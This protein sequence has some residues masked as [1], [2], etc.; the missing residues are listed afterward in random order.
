[1][2][3]NTGPLISQMAT[4][5]VHIYELDYPVNLTAARAGLGP[6]RVILGNVATIEHMLEGNPQSVLE[7]TRKCH[8][9]C[10]RYHI[11]GAGCELSPFTPPENLRAMIQYAREHSPDSI[12]VECAQAENI[13]SV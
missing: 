10:G 5:P 2:C 6:N 4:L 8:R 12:P 3:G 13:A 7:A 1:M 11:V 9:I